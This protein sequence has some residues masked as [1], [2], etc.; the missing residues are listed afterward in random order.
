M[1]LPPLLVTLLSFFFF[2]ILSSFL[3]FVFFFKLCYLI[4]Q[5]FHKDNED[6]TFPGLDDICKNEQEVESG[7]E[8]DWEDSGLYQNSYYCDGMF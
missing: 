8:E 3:F 6:L 7:G 2:N 1:H 4:L 5:A